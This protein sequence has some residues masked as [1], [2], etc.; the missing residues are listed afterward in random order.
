MSQRWA[1]PILS[2][3][4]IRMMMSSHPNLLQPLQFLQK[5][6]GRLFKISK[7]ISLGLAD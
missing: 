5:M 7:C 3:V 4:H 2:L 1:S 6:L